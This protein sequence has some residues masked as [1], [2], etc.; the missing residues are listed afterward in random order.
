[1]VCE[2]ESELAV[3]LSFAIRWVQPLLIWFVAMAAIRLH[4]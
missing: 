2:P 3:V 1:M 4:G